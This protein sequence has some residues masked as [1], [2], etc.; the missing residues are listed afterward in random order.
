M[1]QEMD[2]QLNNFSAMGDQM[3]K[4]NEL[5]KALAEKRER[6]REVPDGEVSRDYWKTQIATLF[7]GDMNDDDLEDL[8]PF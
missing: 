1:E 3:T 2:S 6:E 7:D 4:I 5:A 8:M